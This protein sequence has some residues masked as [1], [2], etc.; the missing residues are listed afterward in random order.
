MAAHL[1]K[2]E[3][4]LRAHDAFVGENAPIAASRL[5]VLLPLVQTWD[6]R[7]ETGLIVVARSLDDDQLNDDQ[8][9]EPRAAVAAALADPSMSG[10]YIAEARTV[11]PP[12]HR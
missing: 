11:P 3:I 5:L 6:V 8:S 4:T 10:W 9:V 2:T 1:R 7:S 12:D